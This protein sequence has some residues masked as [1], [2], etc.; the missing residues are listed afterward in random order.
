MVDVITD[1]QEDAALRWP[2]GVY[3]DMAFRVRELVCESDDDGQVSLLQLLINEVERLQAIVEPLEELLQAGFCIQIDSY[4]CGEG[5]DIDLT[6]VGAWGPALKDFETRWFT[7]D[8]LAAALKA[9]VE[10]KRAAQAKDTT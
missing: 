2:N 4:D 7:G 1:A 9:G 5:P 6:V 8:N 10:A 3:P